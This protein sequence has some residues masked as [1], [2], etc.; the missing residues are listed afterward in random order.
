MLATIFQF[1]H[2]P[3]QRDQDMQAIPEFCAVLKAFVNHLQV[4]TLC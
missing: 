1:K 2:R 3:L 4:Q